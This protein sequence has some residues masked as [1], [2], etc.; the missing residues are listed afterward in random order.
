MGVKLDMLIFAAHPDDA[1]IGMGATIRKH[2]RR[3]WK[4]GICDLTEGELSSNGTVQIRRQEAELAAQHLQLTVRTNLQL[5]DRGLIVSDEQLRAIVKVIRT[6][7]PRFVFAPYWQDRHPDHVRCSELVREAIFNAK[8][9]RWMPEVPAWTVEKQY[10][11]FINDTF[12]ADVVV[13]VSSDYEAKLQALQ[14]Y[15]SQFSSDAFGAE[16]VATPLNNQYLLQIESRDRL[17]GYRF[18]VTYAEGFICPTPLLV[19]SFALE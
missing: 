19:D 13:D 16:T 18:G 5:P 7:R 4:V 8:L 15:K 10:Y 3:G 2:T 14:A 12:E 9:R 11:Y 1:E 17:L 6:Y